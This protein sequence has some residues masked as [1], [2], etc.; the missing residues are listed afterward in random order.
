MEVGAEHE[1]GLPGQ[2]LREQRAQHPGQ[3]VAHAGRGHPGVARGVHKP[4]AVAR[5]EHAAIALEHDVRVV[6]LAQLPGGRQPVRLD[7]RRGR[8]K[9]ARR[10]SRMRRDDRVGFA[11]EAGLPEVVALREQVQG[12]GIQHARDVA[13]QCRAQQ[14]LGLFAFA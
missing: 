7:R 1:R 6:A 10:F 12:V 5:H 4:V 14:G 9:Q 3:H 2:A 13:G 8:T 11:P